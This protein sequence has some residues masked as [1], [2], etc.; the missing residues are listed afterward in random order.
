[1]AKKFMKKVLPL[2][3]A[4]VLA[5]TMMPSNL[6]AKADTTPSTDAIATQKTEQIVDEGGYKYYKTDSTTHTATESNNTD[7]WDVKLSKTVEATGT[8]DNFKITLGVTTKKVVSTTTKS[9]AAHVVLVIDR[10]GSM[11]TAPRGVIDTSP[12]NNSLPDAKAAAKAFAQSFLAGTN[13]SKANKLAV[14]SFADDATIDSGLVGSDSDSLQKITN[15]IDSMSADG[16][17][18]IQAG[19]RKAQSILAKEHTPNVADIIVL[20]TDGEPTFSYQFTGTADYNYN[21]QEFSN[22]AVTGSSDTRIGSGSSYFNSNNLDLTVTSY[23]NGSKYSTFDWRSNCAYSAKTFS[24]EVSNPN[25]GDAT[26]W[27]A[28]QAKANTT[29]KTQIYTIGLKTGTTANAVLAAVATDANHVKS[30]SDASALAGIYSQ[31]SSDITTGGSADSATVADTMGDYINLTADSFSIPSAVVAAGSNFTWTLGTP[32]THT[33]TENGA[34]VTTYTYTLSYNVKLNT[35]KF[36]FTVGTAYETNKSAALTIGSV[37]YT[38]PKPTVKGYLGS[39]SFSKTAYQDATETKKIDDKDYTVSKNIVFGS[40]DEGNLVNAATFTLY[41]ANK[42][43]VKTAQ[44]VN[45]IVTFTRVPA[46][47]YTMKETTAPDGY[48]LDTTSYSATVSFGT[49]KIVKADNTAVTYLVNKLDPQDRK[50][51]VTKN[52]LP[53]SVPGESATIGIYRVTLTAEDGTQTLAA[54][55]SATVTLNGETDEVEK[56]AWVGTVTLPTVDVETGHEI[57]YAVKETAVSS[58]YTKLSVS[59]RKNTTDGTYAFTV[60]NVR[61]GE[62]KISVTK[63]W[64]GPETDKQGITVNLKN[65][66][67]VAGTVTLNNGNGFHA[68]FAPV[69]TFDNYGNAIDYIVE[70]EGESEGKIT[71]NG[72]VYDITKE[73]NGDTVTITNTI[74]QATVAVSG[75]KTWKTAAETD[76]ITAV[77]ALYADGDTTTPIDT[78]NLTQNDTSYTFSNLP[79]YALANGGNGHVIVYTVAE[80]SAGSSDLGTVT[81][82]KSENGYD[83]TNTL[84]G[85][86][87]VTVT[88]I[89]DDN[90]DADGT[91]PHSITVDLFANRKKVGSAVLDATETKKAVG[92]SEGDASEG[93]TPAAETVYEWTNSDLTHT[94]ENLDK[95]DANGSLIDYTVAEE[96]TDDGKVAGLNGTYYVPTVD[97]YKITN[98]LNG[99]EKTI[100]VVK[101]WV[102]A[103]GDNRTAQTTVTV[104]GSDGTERKVTLP[105]G[106][107]NSAQVQVP[108]YQNGSRITYTATE[109][110]VAG[111]NNGT[112]ADGVWSEGNDRV[113]FTNQIDQAKK[114]VSFTKTWVG[115]DAANRPEV[116]FT[117]NKDG[118]ATATVSSKEL[119]AD[120]NGVYSYSFTGLDQYEFSNGSCRVIDY[121]VEEAYAENAPKAL[122]DRYTMI[123]NGNAFTNTFNAG[124][125]RV[126]GYKVWVA[127]S[128]TGEVTLGLY[129]GKE[130]IA[131]AVTTDRKYTFT[132][133]PEYNTDGTEINYDVYEMDGENPVTSNVTL[134]T[135]TYDVTYSADHLTVIN[136][137]RQAK[138]EVTVSKVFEGPEAEVSFTLTRTLNGKKDADF[139][140]KVTLDGTEA[141]PWTKTV[142]VD[143]YDDKY[144]Y[145]YTYDVTEDNTTTANGVTTVTLGGRTYTVAKTVTGSQFAFTNTV[146]QVYDVTVTGTKTWNL[147]TGVTKPATIQVQLYADGTAVDGAVQTISTSGA[148]ANT[149]TFTN[150]A[151]YNSSYGEIEYTVKEVGAVTDGTGEAVVYG[152]DHYTVSYDKANITNKWVSTDFYKYQVNRVYEYYLKGTKIDALGTNVPGEVTYGT[153]DQVIT[154]TDTDTYKNTDGKNDYTFVSSDP[155]NKSVTLT[156]NDTKVITLTYKYE[157]NQDTTTVTG[158]KTW[159][160]GSSTNRPEVIF[161]LYKN[162]QPTEKK[163]SSKTFANVSGIKYTFRFENLDKYTFDLD[164]GTATVNKYQIVESYTA[165]DSALA[166]RYTTTSNGNDFTNTFDAETTTVVASKVW[167]AGGYS[168]EVTLGL[169]VGDTKIAEA[170]TK[171]LAYTF[172]KDSAGKNL[173]KYDENGDLIDYKVR[174]MNDGA[175]VA[176][177]GKIT[178]EGKEYAVNYTKD[179][180]GV[181]TVTNKLSQ[182]SVSVTINK[183]WNGPSAETSF[184]VTRSANGAQDTKF[185]KTV[186][187]NGTEDTTETSAWSAVLTGLEKFDDDRYPYTY[188]VTEDGV[189]N[190]QVTL[191]G[192]TYTVSASQPETNIFNFV[193]TVVDPKNV[194]VTVT[195]NW[196][197]GT[198]TDIAKPASIKVQLYADNIAYGTEQEIKTSGDGANTLT[199]NNLPKYNEKYEEIVYTV[200]EAGADTTGTTILYGNDHYT[201]TYNGTTIT[202]TYSSTDVYSYRV[203]RV[204]NYYVDGTLSTANSSAVTGTP[205]SG[206]KNQKVEITD[207]DTYKT[208]DDKTAYTFI[209]SSPADKKVTLDTANNVYVITLTYEYRYTTPY[210]PPIVIPPTNPPTTDIPTTDTP[211]TDVPDTNTPTTDI[212]DDKTPTSESPQTGDPMSLA[213][214]LTALVAAAGGILVFGR[215]KHDNDD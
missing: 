122:T 194:T 213:G 203:D 80:T 23:Y 77:I 68:S 164:A 177:E 101:N 43:V 41:D 140:Q 152:D 212:P 180:Q 204:Y 135:G 154:I 102:D 107:S 18:N 179:N 98:K 129:V 175:A 76:D 128:Y 155:E 65:G 181:W 120:K 53:A 15:G 14:V 139:S 47:T 112:A 37:S 32:E 118:K 25:N 110:A 58:G 60:T 73:W 148:D 39:Y 149:W 91:R 168:K 26:V 29:T 123:R 96:T 205:V 27:E 64:V 45:N 185:S 133:L 12:Y 170:E 90:D 83:F 207:I 57:T 214:A 40:T 34:S 134:G 35:A 85:K 157:I 20:L 10:S 116:I 150:L 158:S 11:G 30:A 188:T 198:H 191:G 74:E 165:P 147:G 55:P 97:G 78:R 95:F 173:P 46:G 126:T 193:N 8:E 48:A 61:S 132:G 136:T 86:T 119:T 82:T 153:K 169:Y 182:D 172:T 2:M 142:T 176:E 56:T 186:T 4:I 72:N 84:T 196:E 88:K 138:T 184:T 121:S 108:V 17:T 16:G 6:F 50:V 104:T 159:V 141:K 81:G 24:F 71:V 44:T 106:G 19:I 22:Y 63:S 145:E 166:K 206:A 113:I 178:L 117:L 192:N 171:S 202:N 103:F 183:S 130:K 146:N 189:T 75:T 79:K 51:T 199:I 1:M 89:W 174:E 151:R 115:G 200:K 210:N 70:E 66:N 109:T 36:G 160:G 161:T 215:K 163:V 21:N 137:L 156:A 114:E 67:K 211:T 3:L 124:T 42:N 162:G 31:I 94:F 38:F 111:Y 131:Q 105:T 49:M 127:G 187:L 99:G 13:V 190:G 9:N 28:D 7:D 59:G 5:V 54:D 143:K 195:K 62:R 93:D 69:P 167:V 52:W 100:T 92:T 144:R 208:T 201:V 209:S 33:T 125:T 87:S 197:M